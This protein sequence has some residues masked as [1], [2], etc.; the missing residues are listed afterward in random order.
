MS[1]TPAGRSRPLDPRESG[2]DSALETPDAAAESGWDPASW[3]E[4]PAAQQPD[5]PD[6]AALASVRERLSALPLPGAQVAGISVAVR[7][8]TPLTVTLFKVAPVELPTAAFV[9]AIV[10]QRPPVTGW[11]G[12]PLIWL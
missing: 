6:P 9:Y 8:F 1:S 7:P 2:P 11:D 10:C 12:P 4:L 5:W 3:R